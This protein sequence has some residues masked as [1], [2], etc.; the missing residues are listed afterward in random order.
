[1]YKQ[2]NIEEILQS[3]NTKQNTDVNSTEYHLMLN[4]RQLH[5]ARTISRA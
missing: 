4:V 2:H 1:M 5:T 3:P